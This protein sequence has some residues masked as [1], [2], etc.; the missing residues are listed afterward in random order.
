MIQSRKQEQHMGIYRF[1]GSGNAAYN[2]VVAGSSLFTG[3]LPIDVRTKKI[4][5]RPDKVYFYTPC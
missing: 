2:I 1:N 5:Y 4:F 3:R